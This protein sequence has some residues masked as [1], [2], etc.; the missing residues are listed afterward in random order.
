[1]EAAEPPQVANELCR[2]ETPGGDG[3]PD[4]VIDA[5]VSRTDGIPLFVE[6]L[7]K[8]ALEAGDAEPQIPETL[9]AS[10]LA[11]LDRLGPVKHVAQVGAVIGREFDHALL[12]SVINSAHAE[13]Q[14]SI[15]HL[16]ASELVYRQG[17]PPN[18]TYVFKHALVQ[19]A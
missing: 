4:A 10:L 11:R 2:I 5:I 8:T 3:L 12:V 1:V 17:R 15:E 18:I 13:L 6:E 16:I 19:Q 9:Q 7:T 14:H